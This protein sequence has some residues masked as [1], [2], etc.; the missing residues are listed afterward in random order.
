MQPGRH[1]VLAAI[2]TALMLPFASAQEPYPCEPHVLEVMFVPEATVRLREGRL[3]DLTGEAVAGV[4]EVLAGAGEYCWERLAATLPESWLDRMQSRAAEN[5]GEFV[6]NFNNY[7]YLGVPEVGE[8]WRLAEELEALPGVHRAMPVPRPVALPAIPNYQPN[9]NYLNVSSAW[10]PTGVSAYNAWTK[11]WG[12]GTSVRIC[13]LEY[14][15]NLNH[16]DLTRAKNA[17]INPFFEATPNGTSDKDHGTAVLGELVADYNG[18]GVTGIA[19]GAIPLTLGTYYS[20]LHP[21]FGLPIWRVPEV[22][23]Y[24]TA[25]LAPGD[26]ILLE[27]Q[28]DH[29]PAGHDYVPIEW[30]GDTSSSQTLN[31]VYAAIKS[32][33]GNG[34]HVVEAAGN[35]GLD[36]DQYTW[37]GDSGAAIVGAGGAY[38]LNPYEAGD[39]ERVS[40]SNYGVRVNLQGWGEDV[41]TTGYGDTY[42][43]SNSNDAFTNTFAGTSSAA[44]MVAAAM[45]SCVGYWKLG[46]LQPATTLPPA[47]L[48]SVLVNSGTP[49]IDYGIPPVPIGPRPDLEKAL[50]ALGNLA[51]QVV[52]WIDI[53]MPANTFKAGD[54]FYIRASITNNSGVALGPLPLLA[55][56]DLGGF[57]LFYPTWTNKLQVGWVN[58]GTGTQ[59]VDLFPSVTWPAG[60]GTYYGAK[61]YAA[62]LSPGGPIIGR[63]G[64]REFSWTP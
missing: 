42:G 9:Q 46:L 48:R 14:G 56:I 28:W 47:L 3:V 21:A 22:I 23:V 38:Q 8:I 34:I 11:A 25:C 40:T 20:T 58:V 37:Y 62:L 41:Y 17:D 36:L 2:L 26:V 10:P 31:G 32:A 12:D 5:L 4:E 16:L 33:V 7:Y 61:V 24:A 35:G 45:A 64:Y 27:Q 57:L 59:L 19:K 54:N 43:S 60:L 6:Y 44:P 63:I 55:V 52:Q 49:Q 18:W 29:Y 39:L 15:W 50:P 1:A 30:W 53:Q 51:P 13:D